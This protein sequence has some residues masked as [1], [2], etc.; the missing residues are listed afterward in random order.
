MATILF[1][2][3]YLSNIICI[4]CFNANNNFFASSILKKVLPSKN[5]KKL[6]RDYNINIQLTRDH[7][8]CKR[9]FY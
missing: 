5:Y 4:I 3:I 9:I 8:Y 6:F 1:F 7:Y 2:I